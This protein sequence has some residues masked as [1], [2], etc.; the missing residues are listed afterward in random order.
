MFK[1]L[2]SVHKKYLAIPK[3]HREIKKPRLKVVFTLLP[4]K[5]VAFLGR[6]CL[7]TILIAKVPQVVS[8]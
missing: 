2:Y 8:G 3:H 6:V 4:M 7:V 5:M 1:K